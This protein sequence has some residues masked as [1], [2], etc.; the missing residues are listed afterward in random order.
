M[1]EQKLGT[2]AHNFYNL[3][4]GCFCMSSTRWQKAIPAYPWLDVA[5]NFLGP[6]TSKDY[7][8]VIVDYFS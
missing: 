2:N 5:M 4:Q 6:F 1:F 7:I 8:F 3:A